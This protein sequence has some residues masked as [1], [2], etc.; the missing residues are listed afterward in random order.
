MVRTKEQYMK[1]LGR[2]KSNLYYDGKEFDRLDDLQM[3]CLNTIGTTF[4]VFDDPEYRD[5]IQVKSHLTG[6]IINRFTHVH[7]STDDLH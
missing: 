6:E 3:P 1:D 2:M 4:D 7:H 5:L